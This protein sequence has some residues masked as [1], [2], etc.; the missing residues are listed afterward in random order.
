MA[1]RLDLTDI[2]P[3]THRAEYYA[4]HS[5]ARRMARTD[6][7]HDLASIAVGRALV[8]MSYCGA[9]IVSRYTTAETHT[10][11]DSA[12]ILRA[13]CFRDMAAARSARTWKHRSKADTLRAIRYL[14]EA[15][16]ARMTLAAN[17]HR[18]P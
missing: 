15:R 6:T 18:L 10:P 8:V 7:G 3:G 9:G 16:R 4:A 5:L 11:A 12:A 1:Y 2:A 17:G 13:E 14:C